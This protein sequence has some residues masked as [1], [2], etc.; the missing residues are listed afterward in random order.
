VVC[1][2]GHE[3]D[4]TI[5]DFAADLRA[6]TPTAAAELT[7][8][9]REELQHRLRLFETQLA[10]RVGQ[11]ITRRRQ[12]L[13]GE[14]RALQRLSPQAGIERKR[15]RLDELSRVAHTSLAHRLALRRE[16]LNGLLLR[17]SSLNPQ[18]TLARGY[19]IVR[20]EEGGPV[21]SR[22]AQVS[23]GD[24]LSV[25]VSDGTFGAMVR[26]NDEGRMTDDE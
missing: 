23:P 3:T 5:A 1:G 2:V 22:V 24:R 14:G 9:D 8:P 20:R 11:V 10:A 17:L 19:A 12:A 6:P 21:V 15:Q 4:F 26:G 25:H 7:T 16:Q 18:A 13:V